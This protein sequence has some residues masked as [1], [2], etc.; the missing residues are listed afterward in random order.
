MANLFDTFVPKPSGGNLFD[1]PIATSNKFDLNTIEGL[2]TR[3]NQVG[4]GKEASAI[5]NTTP[6]LSFL[7]RLGAGLSAF[8]PAQ[9][10]SIGMEKG[11]GAGLLE[12]PKSIVQGIGSAIT[13]TDYQP[14]R[15]YFSDIA[16]KEGITNGIAKFGL[17]FVGDVLLDPSTYFGGA[18]A[19]GV[20]KTASVGTNIG[21]KTVG[22]VAPEVEIGLRMAGTG[23][24]DAF[25][26]AF[27]AGYKATEGAMGDV[28][29]S[30]GVKSKKL[31]QSASDQLANLGVKGL[32]EAQRLEVGLKSALGKQSEFLLGEEVSKD[33]I[34]RVNELFPDLKVKNARHAEQILN[35]L[36][37]TTQKS[38]AEIR[39]NV[40]KI[41][42]PFFE[43]RQTA[44]KSGSLV[45]SKTG[46]QGTPAL[47]S[48][49]KVDDLNR[50]VDG[51]KEQLSKLRKGRQAVG[52][53]GEQTFQ[54]LG[55]A[56]TKEEAANAHN[57]LI[58]YEEQRLSETIDNLSTKL[59]NLK[60]KPKVSGGIKSSKIPLAPEMT[61][62][63]VI[64]YGER[65]IKKLQNDLADKS[66]LLTTATAGRTTATKL[67]TEAQKTGDFSKIEAINPEL[68][69]KLDVKFDTPQQ[70][71]YFAKQQ[72]RAQEFAKM[73]DIKDPYAVYFPFLKDDV[74]KKFVTDIEKSGIRVGSEGYKKQFK[75]IL[76]TENIKL[77]PA[78]AFFTREAQIIADTTARETLQN[79]VSKYG[80]P[81][82]EFASEQEARQAGFR[83][84]KEKGGFGKP[85]GYVGEW[86]AKLFNDLIR[87]EFTTI[88]ALAKAT[89]FDAVTGLFKR[90]V[91]GLFLPF[92]VRNFMSGI[93]QNF[94]TLGVGA[95]NP[96]NMNIGRR[97]AYI[98]GKGG[99]VPN[100]FKDVV[101]G[102]KPMKFGDVLKP[103]MDRFSGDTFY[104]E[105]FNQ[106]LKAGTELK[107][108]AG[109][110]SKTSA[111]ETVKT[112][113][114]GQ[115]G[116]PFKL[117]RTTGQFLEH[118][119]KATAYITA[120]GQGKTIPEALALAER[121]GFDYRAVTA[122]ESQVMRRIMPFYSFTRKNIELQL[123]TLGENP[124]RI[125]Q[126]LRLFGNAGELFGGQI[127]PEEKAQLPSFIRDAL[128]IKLEDTP[129]GLKQYISSFGTPIEAFTQLFGSNPVL[130]AIS[131]MNPLLKAPI[132]I[133]IG[134]DS[135]RQK[136][137]Q[138]VYDAREYKNAP[139]VLKDLLDIREVQKDVLKKNAQGK[140]VAVGK[141][142]EYQAD[143]VK[144]LIARSLFTSRGVSYL[145]QVFGGDLQG[146]VKAMKLVTGFKPQQ[147]N[148][149]AT[150]AVEDKRQKRALT[151]LLTKTGA[152]AEFS[153]PFIPK[154]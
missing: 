39:T 118:Q 150:K 88:N 73:A 53:L 153:R 51:L 46:I 82:T 54:D 119:Q 10:I 7:Q 48:F 21:L 67:I 129:D 76:T 120:L 86:D 91:T 42:K 49:A 93:I 38:V 152:V 106:A 148:L 37:N 81:V 66:R 60:N 111:K 74:V 98:I 125:N 103:F 107:K 137:L 2:S 14:D 6:K 18:I 141:R 109:T 140:L 121:A 26:R 95:L 115:E 138:D 61:P 122:F 151:D 112:L 135:F 63:E 154:N 24:Q 94:E 69:N 114:L 104:H 87:P 4:L 130:R 126:V 50:V 22:R 145:D 108:V 131:V 123:K 15:K 65:M 102:G 31:I 84:L 28:L 134:K 13:G 97:I 5:T 116:I 64:V 58:N 9:A 143:P 17:G 45:E 3:A 142:T 33:A 113:G 23:V 132:E 146:F 83:L 12:Y 41:V 75:N 79:F 105:D 25:G 127:S 139:Q 52:A 32:T 59:E 117:A 68:S 85:V 29:S 36:E 57:A 78:E 101:V 1:T 56:I 144:L 47:G 20:L 72:A 96:I 8:N 27:V 110:F 19:K 70:Q 147:I 80:K 77:D 11:L 124:E 62:A 99:E 35:D 43:A 89:G 136:D 34:Q 40:D 100:A 44:I 133:G 128:G 55:G 71:E 30:M 90:S 92:H 149:E 16:E